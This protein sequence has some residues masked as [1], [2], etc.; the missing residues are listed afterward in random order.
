M[1]RYSATRWVTLV[2]I[3]LAL[4]GCARRGEAP[5]AQMGDDDEFCKA[6]GGPVGS[7]DYVACRK[8]R[9]VQRGNAAA[10]AD[11]AQRNLGEYMLNNNP[12][13]Q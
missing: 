1:R 10:R 2:L 4:G 5:M 7:N 13:R 6:N 12:A 8:N 11:R 3:A 9:D